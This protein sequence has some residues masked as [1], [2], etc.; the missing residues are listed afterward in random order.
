LV[1]DG[2]LSG[3]VE[4]EHEDFGFHVSEGVEQFVDELT[5]FN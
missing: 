2:G 1:E 5:H 4:A 3:A